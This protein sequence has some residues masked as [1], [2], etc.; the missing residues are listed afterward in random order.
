MMRRGI[1]G[2]W[3]NYFSEEQSSFIDSRQKEVTKEYGI[4]FY[5]E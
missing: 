5:Y 3:K 1:I 2:D 4:P